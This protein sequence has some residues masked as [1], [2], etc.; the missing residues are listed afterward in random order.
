M[1]IKKNLLPFFFLNCRPELW[2][3]WV[4][5]WGMTS[6]K[7]ICPT[8]LIRKCLK[9]SCILIWIGI[10]DLEL[11]PLKTDPQSKYVDTLVWF[12]MFYFY[13]WL[14]SHP[15]D[16]RKSFCDSCF[17]VYETFV[18]KSFICSLLIFFFFF[19]SLNIYIHRTD[20][21]G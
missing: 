2:H 7:N 16:T 6:R 8:L 21:T 4:R 14:G 3:S 9:L 20:C 13:A 11:H 5:H 19:S 12:I 18:S 1:N 10:I 15:C 17:Y